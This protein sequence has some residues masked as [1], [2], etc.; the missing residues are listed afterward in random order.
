MIRRDTQRNIL[1]LIGPGKFTVHLVAT[2]AEV[3]EDR[4]EGKWRFY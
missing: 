3:R 2:D 4:Q 1:L